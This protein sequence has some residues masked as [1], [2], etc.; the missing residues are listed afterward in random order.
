M[1]QKGI[2]VHNSGLVPVLKEIIEILFSK[3][4]IKVLFATETFAV[5][6]NMPAKAV[7]MTGLD[8]YDSLSGKRYLKTHEYLQMGGRAGRRGIDTEGI[9]IH[10]YNL[11]DL[12]PIF[13]LKKYDEWK[14][15]KNNFKI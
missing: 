14:Y 7:I 15:P 3:S 5:G 11:F 10:L 9:V 1:W 12:P 6:I 13:E 2:A 4:L 8:K